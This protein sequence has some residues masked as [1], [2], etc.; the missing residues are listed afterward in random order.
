ME[1]SRSHKWGRANCLRRQSLKPAFTL[2]APPFAKN[3]TLRCAGRLAATVHLGVTW[4]DTMKVGFIGLGAMGR[5]MVT[6]LIETRHE[7]HVW[8]RSPEPTEEV[9]RRGTHREESP[10]GAFTGDAVN[11]H[12][13]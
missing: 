10:G 4:E 12:A 11:H 1:L 6:R 8:N 2:C 9:V 13:C 5:G 3:C 7:V